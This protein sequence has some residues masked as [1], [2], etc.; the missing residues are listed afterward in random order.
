MFCVQSTVSK[1]A[2]RKKN[3]NVALAVKFKVLNEIDKSKDTFLEFSNVKFVT[4]H[5]QHWRRVR[6][7]HFV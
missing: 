4:L 5:I 1:V 3:E 6:S 2:K 7:N